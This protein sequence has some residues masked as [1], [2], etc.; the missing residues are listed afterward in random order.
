M[1]Y[2]GRQKRIR[3]LIEKQNVSA[4]LVT[5]PPNIRYLTG[6]TGSSAALIIPKS[7][8]PQFFTD[9]RYTEQARKEVAGAK[10]RIA[11]LGPLRE[12]AAAVGT[13]TGALAVE[14]DHLSVTQFQGLRK[15]AGKPLKPL[16]ALIERLR[17]IK[18]P[19]ELSLIQK[20]IN[21]ASSVF[22]AVI[23]ELVPGV[24]E[25]AIAAEIEYM[26]KRL[27]ADGMSF[28]TIVAAGKRSALPH[29][30]ASNS[31][32]PARGFVVCD[33]GVMISGYCSDMTRTV[34]VGRPDRRAESVYQAVLGAQLAGIKAV[35]GGVET[36]E[37]D[38][39]AR[40]VLEKAGLG[41]YFTH[42]T[43]HGVGLEIHEI[44]GLRKRPKSSGTKKVKPDLLEPG[45]VVTIE[46]GVYIPGWG[47]VRIEDMVLVT[48]NGCEVLTPTAKELVVL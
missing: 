22:D 13:I 30:R 12:A 32:I 11:T 21:L 29:G 17:T 9:G 45:M 43:G 37:V 3:Q 1:D 41:G 5:H 48:A 19:A 36:S 26:S 27:G 38:Y 6:F 25:S 24:L 15:W 18:E 23:P 20:A 28:E 16:G 34:H 33:F 39:A 47:G 46:P 40:K 10:I 44:P 14:G 31:P 42:S 7:G 8:T 2:H 4:L 35:K